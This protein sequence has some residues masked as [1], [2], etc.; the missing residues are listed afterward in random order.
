MVQNIKQKNNFLCISV[1]CG[2]PEIICNN[3]SWGNSFEDTTININLQQFDNTL[4]VI[5][6]LSESALQLIYNS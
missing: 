1:I 2:H 6:F 4:E 5:D 3:F